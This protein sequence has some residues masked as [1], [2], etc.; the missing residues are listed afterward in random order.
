MNPKDYYHKWKATRWEYRFKFRR[1]FLE[2]DTFKGLTKDSCLEIS[3]N[4]EEWNSYYKEVTRPMYPQVDAHSLPYDDNSFDCV[5]L[6]EVLEHLKK[7]WVVMDE[8]YRV[9]KEG[10]VV[11]ATVPFLYP[12]HENP[13]DYWRITP[14]GMEVLCEKFSKILY[15][16]RNGNRF[17]INKLMEN[18][19]DKRSDDIREFQYLPEH[20]NTDC[21]MTTVT[22]AQK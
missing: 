7:P 22:V 8:V 21:Y 14:D 5:I 20:E 18:I 10:G 9:L 3:G 2:S 12:H 16:T 17:L 1:D 19:T 6:Q 15:N 11:I 13:K 4:C